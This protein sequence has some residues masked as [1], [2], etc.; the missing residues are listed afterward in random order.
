MLVSVLIFFSDDLSSFPTE[1]YRFSSVKCWFKRTFRRAVVVAQLAEQLFPTK[2]VHGS[3]PVIS[4]FSWRTFVLLSAV[5]KRW[6]WR[7]KR[8]GMYLSLHF[9]THFYWN[10]FD[11]NVLFSNKFFVALEMRFS[12]MTFLTEFCNKQTSSTILSYFNFK[13]F[14]LKPLLLITT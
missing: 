7:K 11:Q 3:N 12:G 13:A 8:P 5:L 9:V 10:K 6:K 1:V 4:E 14:W 2:E